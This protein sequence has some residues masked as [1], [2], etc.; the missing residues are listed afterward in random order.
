MGNI[1]SSILLCDVNTIE[2]ILKNATTF[3][4]DVLE[5]LLE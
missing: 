2:V 4:K 5:T 3:L 1:F